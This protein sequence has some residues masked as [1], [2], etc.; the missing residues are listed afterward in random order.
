MLSPTRALCVAAPPA[1][2]ILPRS[3]C[4]IVHTLAR[5]IRDAGWLAPLLVL[6]AGAVLV[7]ALAAVIVTAAITRGEPVGDWVSFYAAGSLVRDGQGVLLFDP[8]TQHAAQ[9]AIFNRELVANAFPLPAFVACVFAPLTLLSFV[10]SYWLWFAVNVCALIALGAWARAELRDVNPRLRTL[11]IT[12]A[13][14]STP[15][16]YTLVLGQVDLFLVG[17]IVGSML[18]LRRGRPRAAGCALGLAVM[19][20]HLVAAVVL[21]LVAKRQWSVLAAFGVTASILVFGPAL[22]L[23][24]NTLADQ[25]RLIVSYPASSTDHNVAAAMMVNLRG[26][27]VSIAP[28]ATLWVWLPPLVV[29]GTAGLAAARPV[30]RHNSAVSRQSWAVALLLPLLYA[31]HL[32]IQSMVLLLAAAVL[33]V[34]DQ[35][36][37]APVLRA[38]HVLGAFVLIVGLWL[39]SVAGISLLCFVSIAACGFA[40]RRWPE[41]AVGRSGNEMKQATRAERVIDRRSDAAA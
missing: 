29:I 33:F 26:F 13:A 3:G 15:V 4:S 40:L 20:P 7:E 35:D 27:V 36:R 16:M 30:W 34:A 21:L 25:A 12:C 39:I 22:L 41:H 1:P 19:K 8:A 18:L 6:C 9:Q 28:A 23:G 38:E 10:A 17:A 32:H 5:S 14:L 11:V 31:P 24:P 2:P 37:E